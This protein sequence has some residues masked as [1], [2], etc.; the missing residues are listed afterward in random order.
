[1]IRL[2]GATLHGLR[3]VDLDIPAGQLVV[4]TGVSGSGK[5][6]LAFDTLHAESLRRFVE[7]LSGSARRRI[8]SLPAPPF[9]L[10]TGLPPSVGLSQRGDPGPGRGELR[11]TVAAEAGLEDLLAHLVGIRGTTSCPQCDAVL[12]SYTLD[13]AVHSLMTLPPGLRLTVRAPVQRR[14]AGGIGPL[15]AR[16]TRQGV[17][18]VEVDG[19]VGL[20]DEIPPVDA[21]VPHDVDAVVDRIRSGPER[22][23]RLADSLAVAWA[24]GADRAIVRVEDEDH[25]YSR[26][27]WCAVH[28]L[29][30]PAPTPATLMPGRRSG[31]CIRCRG[32]GML[33]EVDPARLVTHPDRSLE[34]GALAA[35]TPALT[36]RLRPALDRLEIPS[37]VAWKDLTDLQRSILLRGAPGLEGHVERLAAR[38]HTRVGQSVLHEARCPECAGTRLGVAGRV[39][40]LGGRTIAEL[41]ALTVLELREWLK[42][43]DQGSLLDQEMD[44][45]L[46]LLERAGLAYLSL[47]RPA[48]SLSGG[49]R[50]R[51]RLVAAAATGVG[52]GLYVLDEPT[53]GL[54]PMEALRLAEVIERLH[55]GF[56]T[57]G[58]NTVIVVEHDPVLLRRADRV[59]DFGPGAGSEGGQVVYDGSPAGL[60]AADTVTGRWL[61]GRSQLLPG[62]APDAPPRWLSLR[63]AR[64]RN[65]RGVDLRFPLG[66]LVGV[67][68]RSGSG[69]SSLVVDTL[70]RALL[71]E[72]GGASVAPL[73]FERIDGL[74]ALSRVV[75]SDG[76]AGGSLV[77]NTLGVWG[78]LR[79]L[80]AGTSAART[81]GLT[82]ES[83]SLARAGARCER[84]RGEGVERLPLELLPPVVVPCTA[85]EGRRYQQSA[86]ELR[87]LGISLAELLERPVHELRVRLHRH[88]RIAGVLSQMVTLGLGHLSLGRSERSLSGGERQRLRL[89]RELG[90]PGEVAGTLYVLDEPSIGLHPAD[91]ER[92]LLCLRQL[93]E[94]GGSVLLVDHDPRL[95]AVMDHLIELGPGAG[96]SG[97]QVLAEGS[98]SVLIGESRS[99]IGP[100][101]RPLSSPG[102]AEA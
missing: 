1:M 73:P 92:L 84:C 71:V 93:V 99:L 28:D 77:V 78:M 23:E 47:D 2:R 34:R 33:R 61:S 60:F 12:V 79:A 46:D 86:A 40:R 27:P 20:I 15:L 52:G 75:V 91:L 68:G 17:A 24:L 25:V 5:S 55:Q 82:P 100:Y 14:V 96:A 32:H 97:G 16:L 19:K 50:R 80:W 64:G 8:A 76:S 81:L 87:F 3:D 7:T 63:G 38:A 48:H 72:L 37:D 10:L 35:W 83:L 95:L 36:R 90:R 57:T 54:H 45:R 13:Q 30:V 41:L 74:E 70:A 69:K 6:S 42:D 4:L 26:A 58:P 21:R 59:I 44:R 51:V 66:R 9:R 53:A 67:T 102:G 101:L 56:E 49:E 22:R 18:R 62:S 11:A 43:I 94:E 88:R 89:S 65:L 39:V 85:C 31:W 98:P 29:R